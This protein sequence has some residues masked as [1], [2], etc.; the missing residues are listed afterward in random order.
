[1]AQIYEIKTYIKNGLAYMDEYHYNGNIYT[2]EFDSYINMC[3]WLDNKYK[4]TV[5][6]TKK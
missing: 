5:K 6:I 4:G 3:N 1:M 2:I